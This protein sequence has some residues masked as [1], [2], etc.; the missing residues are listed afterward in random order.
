MLIIALSIVFATKLLEFFFEI[1]SG[2]SGFA[3]AFSQNTPILF[4]V[5]LLLLQFLLPASVNLLVPLWSLSVEFYTNVI[6][7]ILGLTPNFFRSGLGLISGVFLLLIPG[8]EVSSKM[9]FSEYQTWIVCF[10]RCIVG[11][12]AGQICW[13]LYKRNFIKTRPIIEV[14]CF[15]TL[16]STIFLWNKISIFIQIPL[17]FSF[18]LLIVVLSR[19]FSVRSGSPVELLLIKLGETSFGVYLIH[20]SIIALCEKFYWSNK[21]IEFFTVYSMTLVV[22]IIC[23]KYFEK[24][25]RNL[26]VTLIR[27]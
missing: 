15:C 12:F 3:P 2:S 19:L 8:D 20:T 14:L 16:L 9:D 10:G 5:N 11:F 4:I 18:G 13:I 26:L 21:L 27:A 22:V 17:V 25:V 23:N 24:K 6:S 1:A 7:V